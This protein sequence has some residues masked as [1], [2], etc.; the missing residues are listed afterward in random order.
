MKFGR[1][2]GAE[3]LRR[4]PIWIYQAG[5]AKRQHGRRGLCSGTTPFS[6]GR[7]ELPDEVEQHGAG[8]RTACTP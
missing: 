4:Q 6:R 5:L 3:P 2:G 7:F 8:G 1:F